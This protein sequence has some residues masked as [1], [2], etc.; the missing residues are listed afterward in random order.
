MHFSCA[1]RHYL[2]EAG[3]WYLFVIFCPGRGFADY[4]VSGGESAYQQLCSE[5]AVEFNECSK[6]VQHMLIVSVFW[7]L[8]FFLRKRN[9]FLSEVF[10]A[11]PQVLEMESLFLNP[12]YGRDDLA[13][14]LRSVQNQEKQKLHLVCL[15]TSDNSFMWSPVGCLA[16]F[17]FC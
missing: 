14:L 5:I 8:F 16:L 17:Y 3:F 2:N 9:C 15:P 1:S 10:P 7:L 11:L 13:H 12:D 6:Q 4:M